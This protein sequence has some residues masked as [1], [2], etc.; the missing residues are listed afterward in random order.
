MP[1]RVN[2]TAPLDYADQ[3]LEKM[4]CSIRAILGADGFG[5]FADHVLCLAA[6]DE[7]IPDLVLMADESRE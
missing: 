2:T 3:D 7:K 6:D 4:A 1:R 5:R